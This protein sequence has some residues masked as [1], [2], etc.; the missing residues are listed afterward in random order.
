MG[1]KQTLAKID[2]DLDKLT[3]WHVEKQEHDNR[4]GHWDVKYLSER[5]NRGKTSV[6]E[7]MRTHHHYIKCDTLQQC[8]SEILKFQHSFTMGT[9]PNLDSNNLATQP[10]SHYFLGNP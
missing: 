4:E 1:A 9:P 6:E 10:L 8:Q 5:Y 2:E 3:A 7:Y